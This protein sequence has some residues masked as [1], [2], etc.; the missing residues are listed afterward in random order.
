MSRAAWPPV[1]PR[2]RPWRLLCRRL[3]DE[4]FRVRRAREG[5]PPRDH[6]MLLVRCLPERLLGWKTLPPSRGATADAELLARIR[7]IHQESRGT[8]GV[9]RI[10]A[11]LRAEGIAVGR[12][13]V[14][15]LMPAG[16][17]AGV[18]R[19][20][21]VMTTRRDEAADPSWARSRRTTRP[22]RRSTSPLATAGPT[23]SRWPS[24]PAAPSPPPTPRSPVR[25]S[26]SSSMWAGTSRRSKRF[27][28]LRDAVA[29]APGGV[30]AA[31]RA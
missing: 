27:V 9:P 6:D 26:R 28:A 16:G 14:A 10:H 13:R 3:S 24:V 29:R 7:A 21:F 18:H 23:G 2:P 30:L 19:R 5:Q 12:K 17:S 1:T 22:D 31:R 25:P 11:A 20:R 15:R 4:V 8:Y